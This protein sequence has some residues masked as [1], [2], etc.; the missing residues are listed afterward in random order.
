MENSVD[1]TIKKWMITGLS[2]QDGSYL[3]ET[4]LERGDKVCAII[5]RTSNIN[6]H[7]YKHLLK[8]EE[9]G[10]LEMTY[11]DMCDYV[12]LNTAVRK[13]NPDYIVNLAAQ[14]HVGISFD[15]PIS[16]LMYNGLGPLHLLE[17]I[18]DFNPKIR[19]Y[20]ASSSEL[21]G[22]SPPPQNEDT[23][24][25]PQSPYGIAKLAAYHYVRLYRTAYGLHASNGIL[26]NHE[27]PR[28][29]FN[30][31]TRKIT[32]EIAKI[33]NGEKE[34]INLGNLNATRDWGYSK[35]YMDAIIKIIERDEPIDVC[36]ATTET[37][38]IEEFLNE[39]F[40]LLEL[41]WKDYVEIDDKFKRPA[42]VPALLGNPTKAKKVLGWEAN[43]KFKEL[44][45][46]ML[47]TDLKEIAGVTIEQAKEK[48]K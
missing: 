42:E 18:R 12:S 9:T 29:G 36:I 11:A 17:I 2:G 16:T 15:N 21:F 14:S 24:M 22:I 30:F 45:I 20:Q 41:N 23:P 6:D 44:I 34:K 47:K 31:V 39:A 27:S 4:L 37:H 3:A 19:F 46:M 5:R 43:T 10:Q 38:S 26:F 40:K 28:R 8:Y 13:F 35:D 48:M 33:V 25:L 1:K 32:M 7:R